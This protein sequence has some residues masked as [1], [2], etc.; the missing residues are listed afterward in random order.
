MDR[1]VSTYAP[2]PSSGY[3]GLRQQDR[4]NMREF[5]EPSGDARARGRDRTPGQAGS[6]AKK[7]QLIHIQPGRPMQNGHVESFNGAGSHRRS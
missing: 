4:R 2:A 7:I 3:G 6:D 1:G 5:I